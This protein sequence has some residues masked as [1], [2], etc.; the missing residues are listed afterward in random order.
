MEMAPELQRTIYKFTLVKATYLFE[1][2][3]LFANV[4]ALCS[5]S[6]RVLFSS[7]ERRFNPDRSI[8]I[9]AISWTNG[10]FSKSIFRLQ[11]AKFIHA[12]H[13]VL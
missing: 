5:K 1:L 11:P 4:Q 7:N 6:N 10:V 12:K 2:T 8:L 3:L 13:F 9:L